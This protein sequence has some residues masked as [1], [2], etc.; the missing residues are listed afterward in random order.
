MVHCSTPG[1]E[2]LL[3]GKSLYFVLLTTVLITACC[4]RSNAQLSYD[5][6]EK[7]IDGSESQGEE[8]DNDIRLLHRL[9]TRL[10]ENRY[11]KQAMSLAK[12]R[13][14]YDDPTKPSTATISDKNPE[15]A[16]VIKEFLFLANQSVAQKISSQYPEQ[17]LLRRQSPPDS[18]KIVGFAFKRKI[19]A[20]INFFK[21]RMNLK[22]M[23]QIT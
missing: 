8:I 5:N 19:H 15:I 17:A 11:T 16:K 12:Q 9:A 20:F 13:I 18:R 2:K 23:L 22:N 4:F 10:Y 1:L 6:V 3:S 7:I 21:Y 14:V